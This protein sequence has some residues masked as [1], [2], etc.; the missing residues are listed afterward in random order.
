M[1]KVMNSRGFHKRILRVIRWRK[2]LIRI[3]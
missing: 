2:A 1:G 3:A